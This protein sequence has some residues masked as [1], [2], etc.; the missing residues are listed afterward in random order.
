MG[1]SLLGTVDISVVGAHHLDAKVSN[2]GPGA[3]AASVPADWIANRT[4]P[5]ASVS[6]G[7][8]FSLSLCI[9]SFRL[10]LQ[11]W[12]PALTYHVLTVPVASYG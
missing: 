3:I 12:L 10:V 11:R 4:F 7:E 8:R 5:A 6:R 2:A 9:M 1:F